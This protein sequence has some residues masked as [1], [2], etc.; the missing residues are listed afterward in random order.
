MIPSAEPGMVFALSGSI[1]GICLLKFLA[2]MAIFNRFS[3]VADD[4]VLWVT[5]GLRDALAVA[6]GDSLDLT[7]VG[8]VSVLVSVG[9]PRDAV[10]LTA[11]AGV[12]IFLLFSA[13]LFGVL[14]L[15][16]LLVLVA[17]LVLAMALVLVAA[18]VLP[19]ALILGLVLAVVSLLGFSATIFFAVVL[20]LVGIFFALTTLVFFTLVLLLGAT[21]LALLLVAALI[22]RFAVV[23]FFTTVFFVL[24]TML[25]NSSA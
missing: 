10:F 5:G 4:V 3:V 14:T 18:L 2:E 6:A 19:A 13:G 1:S 20:L 25:V 11:G 8:V 23:F 21:G 17:T 15:A 12:V 16:A 7:S 22:T 9:L 24:E